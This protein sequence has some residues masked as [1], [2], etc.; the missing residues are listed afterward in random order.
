MLLIQWYSW[1][2]S[3][4]LKVNR[5]DYTEISVDPKFHRHLIGKGGVN[6]K[7]SDTVKRLVYW[8]ATK[9]GSA[10][11]SNHTCIDFISSQSHQRAAQS[12]C[13]HPPWQR[14]K[15]PDPYWGGSPGCSGGQEGAAWAC[16]THGEYKVESKSKLLQLRSPC[17]LLLNTLCPAGE[18]AYKGP[19]HWTAFSQS[20]HWPK[21]GEDK[22]SARQIPWGEW[23]T[24]GVS[25]Y[26]V[27][28]QS[29]TFLKCTLIYC[30][31][32]VSGHHQF[33][34]PSSEKWHCST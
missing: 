31:I 24:V 4:T 6:S 32:F 14:E 16:V 1:F 21:R 19:D 30:I 13:P 2:L 11:F 33:P 12:D 27:V 25:W 7:Y 17:V 3:V 18:R 8:I 20:H 23:E 34:R 5:M 28:Y 15:Q 10:S 9:S 26:M 29:W 22:R